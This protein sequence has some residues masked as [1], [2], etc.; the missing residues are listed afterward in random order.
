MTD[1]DL[2][3]LFSGILEDAVAASG[4][5]DTPVAQL[6]QPTQ[7]SRNDPGNG[8]YFQ[9]LYTNNYGMPAKSQTYNQEKGVFDTIQTQQM[10][11]VIQISVFY[12]ADPTDVS[13]LSSNDLAN[14]LAMRMQSDSAIAR[15]RAAG[16]GISRITSVRNPN[17]DNEQDQSEFVPNFDISI[18]YNRELDDTV[19]RV[20]EVVGDV[21]LV[22]RG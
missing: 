3:E 4:A 1:L 12:P 11:A 17:F 5:T 21:R 19:Q 13:R 15:L 7:Q 20:V 9:L 2:V 22:A 10:I 8:V 16:A 18:N 6:L 14:Q